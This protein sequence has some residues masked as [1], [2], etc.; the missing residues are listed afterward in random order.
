MQPIPPNYMAYDRTIVVFSPDGRLL[1]V[2]YARQAVKRGSTAIGIIINKGVILGAIKSSTPLTIS[3][4]SKK[5]FEVDDHIGLVGSGILADARYL[6]EMARVKSQINQIT[7]GEPI[8]VH[9]LTKYLA[10]HKHMATQYAG[11]RPFGVGLLIGGADKTGP[12]LYETDPSGTMIE[13]KAQAIGRGAER[14]KK[15][16][17]SGFK[18]NMNEKEGAKLL[19][20]A[21]KSGEKNVTKEGVEIAIITENEFK[22]ISG[23]EIDKVLK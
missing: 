5:V 3:E 11:L 1:Q 10:N 19:L 16:L 23:P 15:I 17:K 22:K 2:E 4:T 20:K 8:S 13:W 21:L 6:V 14:A 7:Y 9:T 18:E 12:N